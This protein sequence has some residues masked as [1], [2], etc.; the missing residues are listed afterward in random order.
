MRGVNKVIL[1]GTLGRDPE[2][3]WHR[4]WLHLLRLRRMCC[5]VGKQRLRF[6]PLV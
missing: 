5:I 4:R 3:P 1:V 6:R 2:T